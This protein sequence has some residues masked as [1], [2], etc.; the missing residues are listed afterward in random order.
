MLGC[1]QTLNQLLTEIDGFVP[2]SNVIFVAATNR[3]NMLDPALTRA[4]RF[5]R[6]ITVPRPDAKARYEILQVCIFLRLC[7]ALG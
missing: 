6:V 4:G 5:D 2:T 3:A 7:Q 1:V